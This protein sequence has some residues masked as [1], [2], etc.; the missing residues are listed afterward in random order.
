MARTGGQDRWLGAKAGRTDVQE[1]RWPG[2]MA[3]NKD[4]YGQVTDRWPTE[5]V[6]QLA[7]RNCGHNRWLKARVDEAGA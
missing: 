4:C 2:Q 5:G 6:A 7:K 3:K 1:K